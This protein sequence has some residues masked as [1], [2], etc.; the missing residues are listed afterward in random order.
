VSPRALLLALLPLLPLAAGP[1][2][3]QAAQVLRGRLVHVD[4]LP[5]GNLTLNVLGHGA[6]TTRGNGQ[7]ETAIARGAAEVTVE[8]VGQG[9]V[10]LYP[11]GGR[12][13][14]PRDPAVMVEIVVGQ[15]VEAAALRLFAER[16]ERM[17]AGLNAVGAGQEE[18]QSILTAFMRE[19]T[20]RLDVDAGALEREVALQQKRVEHFPTLSATVKQ[21][22][23][24]ARDLTTAFELYS[25][26]GFTDS[27]AYRGLHDAVQRYNDAFQTM[28][29]QRLA[30]EQQVATFWESQ[31]LRSDVRALY[32]FAL[33]DVHAM[34]ILPLNESLA[35]MHGALWG[36]RP[37]RRRLQEAQQRIEGAVRELNVALPELERRADRVLQFLLGG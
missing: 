36:P 32:D 3:A 4:G 17:E 2:A 28:S 27:I 33:G 8:V 21:Y 31:E 29:R 23:T 34:R 15:S 37:D 14:V 22:L 1:A 20:E 25:R 9:W 5:T 6:A 30:F 18:I 12:V 19:V 7:F 16:H 11:R 13:A 35:V 10:V 24:E 26:A